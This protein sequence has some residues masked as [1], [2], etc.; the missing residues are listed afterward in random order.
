MMTVSDNS[1]V[2]VTLLKSI[3]G[4]LHKHRETV[5]AL[6]LRKIGQSVE[7]K[8]TP[9]R[10]GMINSVSHLVRVEGN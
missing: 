5:K 4:R 7:V 8:N 3:S 9:E 2:K 6:G 10:R 1:I